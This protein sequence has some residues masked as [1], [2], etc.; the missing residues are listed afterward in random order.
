LQP[1]KIRYYLV[2]NLQLAIKRLSPLFKRL[3]KRL[4]TFVQ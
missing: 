1:A 3:P 2:K 4:N